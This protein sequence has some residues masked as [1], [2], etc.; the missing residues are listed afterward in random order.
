[1]TTRRIAAGLALLAAALLSGCGGQSG[2][3]PSSATSST[4]S[5]THVASTATTPKAKHHR[6]APPPHHRHP[7]P[8]RRSSYEL[9]Y[10]TARSGVVQPQPPTG[11][12][13]LRGSGLYALPDPHCTPGALNPAVTQADIGRTI[14]SYG[15]TSTVRPA[16]AIT[17]DEKR[18]SMA[19]YGLDGYMGDYEYDHLVP[20]ELGGAT[21]DP[22]NLWPELDYRVPSPY[23]L[24]P[25]DRVEDQLNHEVCAG[26]IS[27]AKAQS[28]IAVDWVAVY[29]REFGAPTGSAGPGG[30]GAG[31]TCTVTASF[32]STYDDWDV[33]VH[34]NQPDATATATDAGGTSATW[35]TDSS[36]YADIYLHASESAS[37]ERLTVRVGSATCTTIM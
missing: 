36:G 21:N 1:M 26:Q 19:A 8:P 17:E 16:E 25:K 6:K 24:N 12:C 9:V 32:S 29:R 2:A 20:L 15:W 3:A 22:R 35:H 27:L 11:S 34:S 18:A 14:C 31:G 7:A 5:T 23:L 10:S 37:G 33:Y 4:A 28:E 13:H 30:G